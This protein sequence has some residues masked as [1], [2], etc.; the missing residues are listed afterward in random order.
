M[1]LGKSMESA[2]A[3]TLLACSHTVGSS[4]SLDPYFGVQCLR[5]DYEEAAVI[6]N[7]STLSIRKCS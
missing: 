2:F 7:S 1:A 4:L 5:V 6:L 3:D